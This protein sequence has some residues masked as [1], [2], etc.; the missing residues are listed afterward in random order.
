[1]KK[2]TSKQKKF[3]F[4]YLKHLDGEK[5]AKAAG[6]KGKDL[7]LIADTLLTKDIVICELNRQLNC[8]IKSLRI[9]KGYVIKK[10]LQIAEFSLVEE[11]ILDKEGNITGKKKLRDTSAA[12]KAID[13]LCKYLFLSKEEDNSRLEAKIITVSNLNDKKI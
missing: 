12:L 8:Q 3:V 5:A 13:G 9:Q 6:Y 11:D 2:L 1:M 7:K 4:E 10:L